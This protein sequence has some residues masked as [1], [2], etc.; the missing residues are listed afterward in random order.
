MKTLNEVVMERINAKVAKGMY[1]AQNALQILIQEGKIAQDFIFEVGTI[2]KGLSTNIQ[3]HPDHVGSVGAVFNMPSGKEDYHIGQHAIRQVAEKLKIPGT[4]LTGLL[5][6]VEWQKTLAYNILNTH[7]G[8]TDRNKVLVRVVG[9]EVRAFLTDQYRRLDSRLIIDNYLDEVFKNGA[10]LSDGFI[11][12]TRVMIE[13]ILPYPIELHT[14]LNGIIMLAF[15]TRY[16]TSDYGDGASDLRSFIMQG[17]C[18]NGM[19][20]Q[21]VLRTIHL[22]SKLPDNL[23]LS[24]KTYELD[25]QTT[26]SAIRDLTKNLFST[27]IIKTRILE[28][29]AASNTPADSSNVLKTLYN[30]GKLMKGESEEIGKLLMQNNPDNGLQGEST[31]WKITQ[32]ITAYANSDKVGE[33]RRMEIQELAG[34][35]FDTI[36]SK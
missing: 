21:S 18:L 2:K 31:I 28:V 24:Q 27:D 34:A 15:G 23:A 36:K 5:Y 6:G 35:M 30:T 25:S 20:R 22:G 19:V 1:N 10:V 32:G 11:D 14:D 12:N 13:S 9:N 29:K 33:R 16:S 4:Y 3:F 17:I 7:N 26:A 8:W